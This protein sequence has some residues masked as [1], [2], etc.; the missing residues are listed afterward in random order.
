MM[1]NVVFGGDG[2]GLINMLMYAMLGVFLCGLLIGRTPEFLGRKIEPRE[3][4]LITLTLLVH[5]IIILIPTAAALLTTVGTE[6]ISNPGFHGM[7]QVLYEFTSSAANNGSG[8]E[9]LGDDTSFWNLMTGVVIFLGRYISIVLLL[10]VA[11]SMTKKQ[12]IPET[13]GTFRTDNGLFT[14]ILV[15][16]VLVIGALTF[17]PVLALGPIAESLTL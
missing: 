14:G 17:L 6:A 12:F 7:T 11:G 5:P 2:V 1:L 13:I 4:K 15:M 3:M 8:F 9:G 10:A 16:V